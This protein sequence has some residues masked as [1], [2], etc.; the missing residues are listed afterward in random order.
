MDKPDMPCEQPAR[1]A[2]SKLPSASQSPGREPPRCADTSGPEAT[3]EYEQLVRLVLLARRRSPNRHGRLGVAATNE[4]AHDAVAGYF[5]AVDRGESIEDSGAYVLGA[6][7]RRTAML[8][9][10]RARSPNVPIEEAAAIAAAA[11]PVDTCET[12]CLMESMPPQLALWLADILRKMTDRELAQRY[13]ILVEAV[14]KRR[15]R[16]LGW[17]RDVFL[18]GHD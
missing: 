11:A 8:M 9:R 16:V 3:R 7:R 14:R 2:D 17:T 5:L 15:Q 4:I 18:S 10:T 12:M 13:G 6:A 1:G